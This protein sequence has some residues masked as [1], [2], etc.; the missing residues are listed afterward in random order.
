MTP[1]EEDVLVRRT[2]LTLLIALLVAAT[3]A[4]SQDRS[5]TG[6]SATR[7]AGQATQPLELP[8]GGEPVRLDPAQ[9]TTRIDNRYWPMTPGSRWVYR[10]IEGQG[11][12]QRVVVTVTDQTKTII[13]IQ[14]RV[15]HDVVTEDG[16][17]V[18]DTYD[19]Y[20]QDARGNIWYLGEDTKEYDNGKVASTEG[21]WQAGVDG[22]QPGILL[23]ADPK[24]AMEYRQEYYKGQAEDAAQVLSLDMR[25]KVPAGRFG[26]L[27]VT[28]EYTPLEPNLVEHKFYAPGVGPVLAITVKGGSSRM[29]LLR[30]SLG[31]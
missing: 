7:P 4:C 30:V 2:T 14:A 22:A 21:S 8:Q 16:Q 13:G 6:R 19:W 5:T 24:R 1:T 11:S 26:R 25:A 12:P 27:L 10:E 23:L 15:V 20:A 29:E 31:R 9:F 17:L 28:K 3:A 18:E